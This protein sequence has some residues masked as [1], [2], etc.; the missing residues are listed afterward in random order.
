MLELSSV[1]SEA[2]ASNVEI[3]NENTRVPSEQEKEGKFEA[4]SES[5]DQSLIDEK[6]SNDV[7]K[8][9]MDIAFIEPQQQQQIQLMPNEES[10]ELENEYPT[11][12]IRFNQEEKSPSDVTASPPAEVRLEIM[13]GATA[14]ALQKAQTTNLGLPLEQ[15]KAAALLEK[16]RSRQTLR[17]NDENSIAN[18]E[19]E[20]QRVQAE[21][22]EEFLFLKLKPVNFVDDPFRFQS[23]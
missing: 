7:E 14:A 12:I 13:Q 4:R 18:Q 16:G 22:P 1:Y 3:L 8:V 6:N 5:R 2:D 15:V 9:H 17:V 10:K 23:L 20:Q 21:H 11:P 19:R